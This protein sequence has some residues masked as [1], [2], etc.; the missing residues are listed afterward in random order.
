MNQKLTKFS[1]FTSSA[2]RMRQLTILITLVAL[3]IV[4]CEKEDN[5]R[6]FSFQNQSTYKLDSLTIDVFDDTASGFIYDTT[7]S[8][9]DSNIYMAFTANNGPIFTYSGHKKMDTIAL[10]HR[11]EDSLLILSNQVGPVDTALVLQNTFNELELRFDL[12][13]FTDE[14]IGYSYL[15]LSR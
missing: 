13:L 3:I 6:P 4:G 15:V 14:V 10:H 2:H 7:A 8:Y 5:S 9:V 12:T 11:F 1:S